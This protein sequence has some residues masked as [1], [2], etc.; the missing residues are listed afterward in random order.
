MGIQRSHSSVTVTWTGMIGDFSLAVLKGAVGYFSGSRALLGDALYSASDAVSA[1][2]RLIPRRLSSKAGKRPN[3]SYRTEPV[4]AIM[5]A[6]LVLMGGLQI[7]VTSIRGIASGKVHIPDKFTLIAIFVFLG[8]KEV[9]FQF[10]Y[11]FSKKQGDGQHTAYAEEHRFS[12]YT[13]LI[14][15]VGV[16]L[17]V[18]GEAYQWRVMMYMDSVSALVVAG[19]V[20]RKGYLLITDSVYGPLV[21]KAEQGDDISFIETV[22]R[23]H[24]IITVDDLKA[25]EQGHYI[26]VD[27][28]ISVNPRITVLEANEIAERAKKLLM[29]R[30]VHVSEVNIQVVPYDPGYPYKSNHQLADN[31]MPTIIQ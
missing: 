14:V 1:L 9:I 25:R 10:Q 5:F 7:A 15:C 17:S 2:N 20:I 21:Q 31:D 12:L 16:F 13:S 28:K 29:N 30:F 27:L 24:G 4:F 8:V 6:V 18:L 26:T 19:L 22:Q 11:R 3:R 23:V